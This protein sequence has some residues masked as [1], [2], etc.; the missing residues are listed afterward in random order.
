MKSDQ[1]AAPSRSRRLG[2]RRI[3]GT[4]TAIALLSS[5]AAVASPAFAATGT[6]T[7]SI[8]ATFAG[9]TSAVAAETVTVNVQVTPDDAT[10][11][12]PTGMVMLL[13]GNGESLSTA[14]LE[15]ADDGSAQFQF[16]P[17][18]VGQHH[19][20]VA[21]AGDT[22][23][24]DKLIAIP[25]FIV[26]A[27]PTNLNVSFDATQTPGD[28]TAFGG[29]L[30]HVI[31]EVSTGV[32]GNFGQPS[33]TISFYLDGNIIDSVYVSGSSPVEP[34]VEYLDL[35][36]DLDNPGANLIADV[37]LQMP[38]AL[39]DADNATLDVVFI[40]TNWFAPTGAITEITIVPTP[41]STIMS[42]GDPL[43]PATTVTGKTQLHAL[44]IAHEATVAPTGF[45]Q[46]MING[47]NFG[48]PVLLVDGMATLDWTPTSAGDVV[49]GAWYQ[50]DH[51]NFIT[52]VTEGPYEVK[53]TLPEEKSA[54]TAVKT[55][56]ATGAH[57]ASI[58]AL[59]T[60]LLIAGALSLAVR[61]RVS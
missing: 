33:G 34:G 23:Y 58:A 18:R 42:V 50:P 41:T 22:V 56:A 31:A 48:E 30:L 27:T 3:A 45:V 36:E 44:V 21:Y 60:V 2:W 13:D 46:F 17:I 61:R 12:A 32:A 11:P 14:V 57:D 38:L 15:S 19:L 47:E 16:R 28:I 7:V 51:T 20:Q 10:N 39:S 6:E 49:L 29:G 52:S 25:P 54:S 4:L 26:Y 40:P 35:S 5:V 1:S 9:G 8:T 37:Y 24:A 55:L 59:A 53:V 43:N